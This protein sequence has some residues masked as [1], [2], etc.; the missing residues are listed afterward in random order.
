MPMFAALVAGLLLSASD[1]PL[2]LWWLQLVALVPFW[3]AL[4][5]RP[6]AS[7]AWPLGLFLGIGYATPLVMA[8]GADPPIL[9]A[10]AAN[11]VQWTL[12]APLAA[13]LLARGPVLGPLAAAAALTLIE[14]AIWYC[15]PMF[16]TAQCFVRPLTAA[17]WLVAFVAW[18][19]VAGL[20]FVLAATQAL[21]VSAIR[22]PHRA[23]PIACI[24]ALIALVA[25]LDSI[26]WQRP[27]GPAVTVATLG[28]HS[29][30]GEFDR[31]FNA[32]AQ[33]AKDNGAVLL[34]TPETG[35]QVGN[36]PRERSLAWL[37]E[38]AKSH[39]LTLAIGVWHGPTGDNRI[40]FV[41]PDGAL[42]GEYRK[43]H[44]IPV[45][46]RY[47]AGDGTL[48]HGT[49]GDSSLGGMIC[50][51][52]N[53][54]DLARSYG[55]AGTRLLAVPTNDWPEICVF[56]LENGIFRSIERTATRLRARP[57]TG[58]RR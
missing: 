20:V 36:V 22:G 9:V 57:R 47:M 44:L 38:I 11:V 32:L 2:R 56:H 1:H 45:I 15:V 35:V 23:P 39:A 6:N 42:Q 7:P 48:F 34:V 5:H 29:D 4:Q 50:Q 40:W 28:W 25:W 30:S 27:L 49:V 3:F 46:E 24:A 31:D 10:A 26:R 12:V 41:G 21:V 58:S 8:A 54:T 17:P 14:V 33:R 18:P 55:R 13:K 37:A 19:G 53:F 52:D 16:G 51:D 43:T